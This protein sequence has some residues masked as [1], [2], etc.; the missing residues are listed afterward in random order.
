[1]HTQRA[2][3]LG[4]AS[5]IGLSACGEGRVVGPFDD[6]TR[7][8]SVVPW[9]GDPALKIWLAMIRDST[10]AFHHEV[11]ARQA[12]YRP[13]SKPCVWTGSG[14]SGQLYEHPTLLGLVPGSIPVSGTDS[15]INHF[16]PE[17]LIYEMQEVGLPKFVGIKFVV[18]RQPWDA[19]HAEP[20]TLL[21]IRFDEKFGPDA[22]GHADYYELHVWI[23]RNNPLACFPR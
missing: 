12:G 11:L 19:V 4:V 22:N 9:S 23:W 6:T 1:M 18:Y 15:V 2:F 8:D 7:Y 3:F 17:M 20:P 10:W 21:G 5:L 14:A 16:R 13:S